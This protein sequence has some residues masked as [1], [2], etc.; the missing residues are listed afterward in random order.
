MYC[1]SCLTLLSKVICSFSEPKRDWNLKHP[2]HHFQNKFQIEYFN[3]EATLKCCGSTTNDKLCR[4]C[5][6]LHPQLHHLVFLCRRDSGSYSDYYILNIKYS[7]LS[8]WNLKCFMCALLKAKLSYMSMENAHTSYFVVVVSVISS[9]V[10]VDHVLSSVSET[11]RVQS[12]QICTL[13]M[14]LTLH[15]ELF[16]DSRLLWHN[17]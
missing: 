4:A 8:K 17:L 15:T 7:M 11:A 12:V 2:T 10:Y 1:M 6:R 13:I 5:C 9:S 16:L 3:P 14:I